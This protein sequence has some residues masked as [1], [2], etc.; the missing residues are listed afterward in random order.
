MT[1]T[2]A[3]DATFAA[4]RGRLVGVAYRVT[5]SRT[6]A[7]DVVQDAWLRWQRTDQAAVACPAA[8]LTTVTS[9]LAL[10]RL[11]SA[12][13]RR[14]AYVGPWLPEPVATDPGPADRAELAESLSIGF[15]AVLERLG[16]VERV[17]FLLAD[18]FSV[19]F[20]EIAEVVDRSPAA[21]R[22]V[23]SRARRRVQQDRPR[24]HPTDAEARR[25]TEAFLGAV[26]AGDIDGVTALLAPDV[27]TTSDGGP[28][29]HAARR[30][31]V[32]PDR[33]ARFL[34]NLARRALRPGVTLSPADLNGQPGLIVEEDG[35]T[36]LALACSVVDGR[37]DRIW[38]VVNPEKTASLAAPPV[39]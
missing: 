11:T 3:T 23:A 36:V 28:D 9:R 16:P 26:G 1:A 39:A 4:E 10:D 33:V 29:H 6:E 22:Q 17:V 35:R 20:D 5:G 12:R 32:G 25:V 27:V 14:E 31:V 15:L 24:F 18:V 19:P 21:C 13:S 8:W 38:A 37:V 30:P 34:V 2:R 7:E